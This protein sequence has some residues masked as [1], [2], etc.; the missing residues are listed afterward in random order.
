M[1]TRL[2]RQE[3]RAR[4]RERLLDAAA[5]VF[6]RRGLERS[7]IDEVAEEAG[8]TKGAVYANFRSKEDLFLAM[9]DGHFAERLAAVDDLL[10]ADGPLEDRVRAAGDEFARSLA[11]DPEWPRMFFEWAAHAA[12]D[13]RFR[14]ELVGRYATLRERLAEVHARIGAEVGATPPFGWE[15]LTMMTFAMANGVALERLLEPEAVP[16]ELYGWML[17]IFLA[18]LRAKA[19]LEGAAS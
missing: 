5:V 12:R 7:T 3:S 18:G 19:G 4:T 6:A 10:A 1:S 13:E 11:E 16:P 15:T 9:L 2:S 17:E 14:A 8:F